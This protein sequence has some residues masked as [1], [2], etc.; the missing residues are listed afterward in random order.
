MDNQ[1][2]IPDSNIFSELVKPIPN[3]QVTAHYT[4]CLG[5]IGLASTVWH[6]LYYGLSLIPAGRR[7]NLI[8]RFLT[9]QVEIL[10]IYV[11]DK[12]CASIQANIRATAKQ[13]GRI[14]PFADS[15]IA[16]IAL[17]NKAILVTRNSKDFQPI[18][19]LQLANWFK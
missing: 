2:F 1:L 11:Y 13:N 15:Q 8:A 16:A 7:K 14:L 4:A 17:R 5:R 3:P 12:S 19:N 9:E 18:D 6:E 10:P